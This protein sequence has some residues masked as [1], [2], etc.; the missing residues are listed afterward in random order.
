MS[1]SSPRGSAGVIALDHIAFGVRSIG[2]VAAD[3]SSKLGGIPYQSGP[4][5][6]FR[7]AQWTLEGGGRVEAIEPDGGSDGFLARFLAARGP[8]F[9]HVTFKVA[10][11]HRAA[12]AVRAA[13]LTIVG[14]N[15]S[16]ASWKE[17]FL[18]PREAQGIVVQLVEA[19]PELGDDGWTST[20]PYPHAETVGRR[21]RVIGLRMRARS[22]SSARAQWEGLLGAELDNGRASQLRF[23]WPGSPLELSVDIS[24]EADEGPDALEMFAGPTPPYAPGHIDALGCRIVTVDS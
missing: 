2:A 6:G 18:H 7:G 21:P 17:M 22:A 20:W 1:N 9:H 10:D 13:G 3:V 19:H 14:L 12:S 23:R 8:G 11:I 15:E 5:I 16:L 24:P 4:G